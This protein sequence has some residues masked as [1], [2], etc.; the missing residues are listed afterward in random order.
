VRNYQPFVREP[1]GAMHVFAHNGHLDREALACLAAPD[2]Y[3]RSDRRIQSWR[4][5]S[6]SNG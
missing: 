4:S 5:A 6:C 1:G 3:G 2:G